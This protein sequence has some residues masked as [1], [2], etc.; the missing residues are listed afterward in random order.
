M[1]LRGC[2]VLGCMCACCSHGQWSVRC[3]VRCPSADRGRVGCVE[4]VRPYMTLSCLLQPGPLMLVSPVV[5][6]MRGAM[7]SSNLL[8]YEGYRQGHWAA[9][10]VCGR[11]GVCHVLFSDVKLSSDCTR[12]CVSTEGVCGCSRSL[13]GALCPYPPATKAAIDSA[14]RALYALATSNCKQLPIAF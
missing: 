5:K 1:L 6:Y 3:I 13:C 11:M 7:P 14:L 12:V 9:A 2:E 8:C 10:R 4:C